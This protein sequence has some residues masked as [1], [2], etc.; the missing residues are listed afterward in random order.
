MMLKT[1][2]IR[3]YDQIHIS[4]TW[5]NATGGNIHQKPLEEAIR[6]CNAIYAISIDR[7]S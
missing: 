7:R 3:L 1:F 4:G 5:R 6:I 2:F